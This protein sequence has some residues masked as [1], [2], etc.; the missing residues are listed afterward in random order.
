MTL[1]CLLV[2]VPDTWKRKSGEGVQEHGDLTRQEPVVVKWC[3]STTG[4][5]LSIPKLLLVCLCCDLSF[6]SSV[7]GELLG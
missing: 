1:Y 6:C 7:Q 2:V 5:N 3:L 4:I